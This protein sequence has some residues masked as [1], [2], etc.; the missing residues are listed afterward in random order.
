MMMMIIVIIIIIIIIINI[1]IIMMDVC[2]Y[3]VRPDMTWNGT[4]IQVSVIPNREASAKM[5]ES[6]KMLDKEVVSLSVL[7]SELY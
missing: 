3:T 1:I 5:A 4:Q 6:I 2:S 7:K